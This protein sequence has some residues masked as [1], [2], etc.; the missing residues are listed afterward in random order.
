MP[1]AASFGLYRIGRSVREPWV[2]EGRSL[3]LINAKWTAAK[4]D[5]PTSRRPYDRCPLVS[6][7]RLDTGNG[8]N[9][10]DRSRANTNEKL[11]AGKAK[12]RI[13]AK[14]VRL[15]LG[16]FGPEMSRTTKRKMG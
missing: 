2:L 15:S 7:E 9:R 13:S 10:D 8:R 6:Q 11:A 12:K 1:K 14:R 4:R 5:S 3:L 16:L